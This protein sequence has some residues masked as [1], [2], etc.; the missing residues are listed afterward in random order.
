[1]AASGA[2]RANAARGT[3]A[4]E[5]V[6]RIV[7]T[8]EALDSDDIEYILDDYIRTSSCIAAKRGRVQ[9][10]IAAASRGRGKRAGNRRAPV[11]A[12]EAYTRKGL[13][14]DRK[15]LRTQAGKAKKEQQ[16]QEAMCGEFLELLADARQRD[17]LRR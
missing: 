17:G 6:L 8:S 9:D 16:R 14:A 1:M 5:D 7:G 13:G 11:P 10:Q 2:G 4:T 15:R 12:E 3:K